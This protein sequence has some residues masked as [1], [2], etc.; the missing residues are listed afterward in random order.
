MLRKNPISSLQ[1]KICVSL[2]KRPSLGR[3]YFDLSPVFAI[4]RSRPE[5]AISIVPLYKQS[6]YA[7]PSKYIKIISELKNGFWARAGTISF[8]L[9]FGP[10]LTW[11]IHQM[12]NVSDVRWRARLVTSLL[13]QE[14]GAR[15]PLPKPVSIDVLGSG[16]GL[17]VID[18]LKRFQAIPQLSISLI[19]HDPETYDLAQQY[20]K[21]IGINEQSFKSTFNQQCSN[22]LSNDFYVDEEETKDFVLMIGVGDHID[23]VI[24]NRV[25]RSLMD[26][27]HRFDV[28]ATNPDLIQLLTKTR[29]ALKSGGMLIYTFVNYNEEEPFM[30][31]VVRWR[32]RY[33]SRKM[34][35]AIFEAS[36]WDNEHVEY[37][38]GPSG[39]QNVVIA[40]A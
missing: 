7:S 37:V 30:E 33:R 9:T 23:K 15:A 20:A 39:V 12:A 25:L 16:S 6:L 5:E 32:H 17:Y 40:R 14:L 10:L 19:D 22:I 18:A 4:V 24:K 34:I 26:S 35:E 31:K 2:S 13:R 29:K 21:Q 8:G 38:T 28:T 1:T 27:E 11:F 3:L 36:G